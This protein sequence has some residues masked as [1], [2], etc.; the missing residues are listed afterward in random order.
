MLSINK[1][2]LILNAIAMKNISILLTAFVLVTFV[3]CSDFPLDPGFGGKGWVDKGDKEDRGDKWDKGDKKDEWDKDDRKKGDDRWDKDDRRDKKDGWDK[4][5]RRKRGDKW[6]K[7]DKDRG[8]RDGDIMRG[9]RGNWDER[10]LLRDRVILR[11][12]G[13]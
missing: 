2:Y 10:D 9:D 5:D 12:R 11:R 13:R 3:G 7:D 8:R 1:G 4:D 6:D